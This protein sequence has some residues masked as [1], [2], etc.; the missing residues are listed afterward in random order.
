MRSLF[1][2]LCSMVTL[3]VG[4]EALVV[5]D[6][7]ILFSL[8]QEHFFEQTQ[9]MEQS[10]L[11]T[12]ESVEYHEHQAFVEDLLA[13]A[14][15]KVGSSYHYAHKGPDSFDCS[16]FVYY[17][18]DEHNQ[19]IARTSLNQSKEGEPL[20]KLAIRRGDKL[21]FDTSS[22]GKV[23]HSGVYLGEGKFIHASSGK[24]K[25]VTISD[26]GGWYKDKFLWGIRTH[27]NTLSYILQDL[28][29]H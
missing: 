14:M 23:N 28:R 11:S 18:F 26:L 24:A 22:K 27:A 9:S 6:Q 5:E 10:N 25:G 29:D 17:L 12:L 13:L 1:L 7:A 20:S 19:S 21:F 8:Y 16:G 4:E 3:L 15:S 2:S